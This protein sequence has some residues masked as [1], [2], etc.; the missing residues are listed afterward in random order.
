M[1]SGFIIALLKKQMDRALM[2][3]DR[4]ILKKLYGPRYR[5]VSCRIKNE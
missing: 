5:N 2:T 4:K 1:T 3:W